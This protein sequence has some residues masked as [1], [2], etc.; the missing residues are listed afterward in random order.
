MVQP[1]VATPNFE[2]SS[3]ERLS[4]K[5]E[6]DYWI[7]GL[8]ICGRAAFFTCES[9]CKTVLG[10]KLLS[11]LYKWCVGHVRKRK[12]AESLDKNKEHGYSHI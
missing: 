5:L 11:D 2:P 1:A 8:K 9:A 10:G 7:S 12:K 4:S 3:M 6:I